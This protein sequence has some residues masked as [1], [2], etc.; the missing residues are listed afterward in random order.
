[1]KKILKILALFLLVFIGIVAYIFYSTGYFRTIE[2]TFEGEIYRKISIP[3]AEDIAISYNDHFIIISS[4][5]RAA[6]RDGD[7]IQGGLY[8]LDLTQDQT[9]PKLISA[10]FSEP[11]YPH[12][13]SIYQRDSANYLVYAINH[14]EDQHSIELFELFGDSLV[15]RQ[16]LRDESMISPND[17]VAIDGESFYFTNDKHYKSGLGILA[18]NYAGLALTNVIYYDGSSYTE[19]ADGI[20]YANGI[21]LDKERN[22]LF[23]ASPRG[24][25]VKVYDVQADGQLSFI[26]DIDCHTGVDNIA[27]DQAGNIWIGCHP[28][29]LSFVAYAG[30]KKPI[31]PSELIKIDYRGKKDYTLESV[32]TDTGEHI[33]GSTVAAVYGDKIYVGNVMDEHV[34]VLQRFK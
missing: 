29:L 25:L 13:I 14:V 7:L 24:F 34:L 11:F 6:A 31:S 16:T 1:M 2:N 32:Y 30:G 8:Y 5:D 28:S 26:E 17:L 4:F 21:N 20:A 3:G 9:E 27:F 15:H 12:G 22:L 19:V 10:D 33:S 23:V 18:E